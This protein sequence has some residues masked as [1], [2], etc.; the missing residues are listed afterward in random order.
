[1]PKTLEERKALHPFFN[2]C[3][4]HSSFSS[5]FLGGEGGEPGKW[6]SYISAQMKIPP[7]FNSSFRVHF[8]CKNSVS[9]EKNQEKVKKSK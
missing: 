2:V 5:F 8:C 4:V 7:I 6:M 9:V 1:M 3:K